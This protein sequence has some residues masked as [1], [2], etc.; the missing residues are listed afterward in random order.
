[1]HLVMKK[2]SS[3]DF[4]SLTSFLI[5]VKSYTEDLIF[6]PAQG[7]ALYHYTDLS[8]LQGIIQNHDLWLTHSRYSNDD[9]EITHGYRIVKEVID[10]E[11]NNAL[12]PERVAFLDSLAELVRE[13]S[14]EGV[15]I[16]CFCLDDNLLSQWRG[17][18]ANGTGVSIRFDPAAFAY[19]TGPDSPHGGLMRLW[20]V[21]YDTEKQKQI[22]KEAI[23]YAFNDQSQAV[24]EKPRQA[25]D[26]IQFF[27]PTFKNDGFSEEKECRLIFTPPPDCYVQPQL[28]VAR[29]MLIPY[30]SMRKLTGDLPN[31]NP[32][33][34][35]G[36]RV[37]PSANKRLNVESAQMLLAH[38]GY[39]DVNVDSSTTPYRG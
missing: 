23:N 22:V 17:Y 16:C 24:D 32:L 31:A 25:A 11:R 28:R 4:H 35:T 3:Q 5:S 38:E 19:I 21:F 27:I 33:P 26:A 39:M 7:Q 14:P 36:V 37:G 6:G 1:M 15:Y 34:I 2:R 29:G 12:P 13:P 18:G 8:G 20:K 30:Y 9:E 10:E